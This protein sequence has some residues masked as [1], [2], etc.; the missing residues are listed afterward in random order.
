MKT[1]FLILL[2]AFASNSLHAQGMISDNKKEQWLPENY[3]SLS[4]AEQNI[5]ANLNSV[6]NKNKQFLQLM[7][8][9]GSFSNCGVGT[10]LRSDNLFVSIVDKKKSMRYS[11]VINFKKALVNDYPFVMNADRSSLHVIFFEQKVKS[12]RGLIPQSVFIYFVYA[13]NGNMVGMQVFA[14]NKSD[15]ASTQISCVSR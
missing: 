11:F 15:G 3:A 2:M 7:L 13:S 9:A 10:A 4:T 6:D 8:D 5:I 1:I 14:K 12:Q